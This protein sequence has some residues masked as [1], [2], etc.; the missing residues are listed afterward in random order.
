M[1]HQ[2][3]IRAKD[4]RIARLVEERRMALNALELASGMGSFAATLNQLETPAPILQETGKKLLSLIRFHAM[5]FYLV[6]EADGDFYLA[7]VEPE[8]ERARLDAQTQQ[9]IRE[10]TFSWALGRNKAFITTEAG[11]AGQAG[12][13]T[14]LLLH[15]LTTISR[16]R[17]MFVGA[18]GQ[19]KESI[20]DPYFSLLTII[21]TG[22][23]HALESFELYR[24]IRTMNRDLERQ[25]EERS[26]ALEQTNR[27]LGEERR[28]LDVAS[29]ELCEKE[30]TLR[31]FFRASLD[32]M[33]ILDRRGVVLDANE[34][35]ATALE[36]S[37][38]QLIGRDVRS[39]FSKDLL[40]ARTRAT[41]DA[42]R[43]GDVRRFE[44]RYRGK[45]YEVVVYP[46][47]DTGARVVKF[48]CIARDVTAQHDMSQALRNAVTSEQAAN[49]AKSEFLA[50]MSHELRTPLNGILGMT[51]LMFATGLSEEQREYA[52]NIL[53]SAGRVLKVVNNLLDLS[54]LEAGEL[55]LAAAPFAPDRLFQAA[56]DTYSAQA[57]LKGL[58]F[59]YAIA[60]DMPP[61]LL[62]DAERLKQIFI[63]ILHNAVNFTD[64]GA[65]DV[66]VGLAPELAPVHDHVGDAA[67][68]SFSVRDTGPGVP[69]EKREHIFDSF[70]VAENVLTKHKSGPGMG[71]AIARKLAEHMG[72][73]ILME[74][75]PASG[76]VF[77]FVAPLRIAAEADVSPCEQSPTIPQTLRILVVEDDIV[78]AAYTT[79]LL[80]TQG[81]DVHSATTAAAA[82][83]ALEEETFHLVLMD[84]QLPDM[85]GLE[86]TRR[87]RDGELAHVNT[88]IP[89]V[90][91]T[92]YAME[93]D[94]D[95]CLRA[96]MNAFVAK[97]FEQETLTLAIASL[98]CTGA[99]P[100]A[101]PA[102]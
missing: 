96:G 90:A 100:G 60:D 68:F 79:R 81:W 69:A 35:A 47:A 8:S 61:Y 26:R 3:E 75:D 39:L 23:A 80:E 57:R 66:R 95:R 99:S 63:N 67:P 89:I 6:D 46:L 64:S 92:A 97:P 41:L 22:C 72:G 74:S 5:A 78:N 29:Q 65:V 42:L 59:T 13:E 48:V 93:G 44:E 31:A 71:L 24:R 54:S 76:S 55:P 45:R 83:R 82:I 7:W 53:S 40:A 102:N 49:Q 56:L 50:N 20:L 73:R 10:Q 87:I 32:G 84:V 19:P 12:R 34:R 62:G 101:S 98:V 91:L 28:L 43:R 38:A 33:L 88:A 85:S 2:D 52:D 36:L 94:R 14:P 25:V 21:F 86:V 1:G 16:V 70:G 18:L 30:E 51:Q 17:G 9:L 77:H 27:R 4:I 15:P 11:D 58:E 37:L